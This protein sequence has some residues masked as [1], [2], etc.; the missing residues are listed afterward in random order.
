LE[1]LQEK[2][3]AF[4]WSVR[5]VDGHDLTALSDILCATPFET[6]KPNMIIA[7]TVKGKGVSYME[8][9]AKWHH[10]VPNDQQHEQAIAELKSR[11]Q[12]VSV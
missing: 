5:N 8:H 4:G 3:T 10:G 6:G 1:S 7:N 9:E 2:F 11:L 12:E